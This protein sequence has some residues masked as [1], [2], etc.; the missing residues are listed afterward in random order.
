MYLEGEGFA[1]VIVPNATVLIL[2][3]SH[4]QGRG[5]RERF[6]TSARCPSSALAPER[7]TNAEILSHDGFSP[8]IDTIR[9]AVRCGGARSLSITDEHAI[10]IE[11]DP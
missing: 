11:G 9:G 2:P 3:R 1:P 7:C 10:W 6:R 5:P 4:V 8:I